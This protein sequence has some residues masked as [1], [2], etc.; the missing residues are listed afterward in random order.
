MP[1]AEETSLEQLRALT[2]CEESG[3]IERFRR[4]F[5]QAIFGRVIQ[6]QRLRSFL[7]MST[8]EP[9]ASANGFHVSSP[10]AQSYASDRGTGPGL[11]A[12]IAG[13]LS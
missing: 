10:R 7:F 4:G 11:F 6:R 1:A 8:P 12:T 5:P 9:R 3:Q 2:G 13:V